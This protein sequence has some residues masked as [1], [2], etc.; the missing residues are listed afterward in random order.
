MRNLPLQERF[1]RV[2]AAT[3]RLA[4]NLFRELAP[5]VL[6]FFVSFMLIFLLFKLFVAQYSI[7]FSAFTKAAVA[8][9]ILGKVVPLLDWAESGYRFEGHR[10]IVVIAAKTLSY[11][12][13]VMVLGIGERIVEASRQQASLRAGIQFLIANA[14]GHRFVGLVLLV[15]LVVGVYLTMQ[16]IERAMGEGALFRLFFE[17]PQVGVKE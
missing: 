12:L 10:R 9:L 7:E 1:K 14:D 3:A 17:R 5:K 15:S 16:E 6:F 13:V 4:T 8:A 11:A 2:P